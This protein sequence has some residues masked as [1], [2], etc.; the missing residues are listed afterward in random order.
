VNK[1]DTNKTDTKKTDTNP[2]VLPSGSYEIFATTFNI[3]HNFLEHEFSVNK[4]GNNH[5]ARQ[6]QHD[7]PV[8]TPHPIIPIISITPT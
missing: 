5:R 4:L 7:P 2:A 3:K 8:L 1:T 6:F